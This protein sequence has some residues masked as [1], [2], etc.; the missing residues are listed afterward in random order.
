MREHGFRQIDVAKAVGTSIQTLH[1][2]YRKEL[3]VPQ[4][5]T[6]DDWLEA[7]EELN[8]MREEMEAAR[9]R[10]PYVSEH[11]RTVMR[12]RAQFAE[13]REAKLRGGSPTGSARLS[14]RD[15]W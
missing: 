5:K 10:E 8:I 1:R 15:V 6:T 12:M 14:E 7:Q 4:I 3:D 13:V 11:R 2:H 9:E